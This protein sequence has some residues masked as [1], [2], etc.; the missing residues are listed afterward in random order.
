MHPVGWTRDGKSLLVLRTLRDRTGQIAFLSI[1]DGSLRVVKSPAG[2]DQLGDGVS[3][4]P[5]DRFIAYDAPAGP[6][7]FAHDIF[8]L[9]AD[10]SRETVVA[11]SRAEDREPVWSPDGSQI[12]FR[13]N[14]TGSMALWTVH[15]DAGTPKGPPE[16]VRAGVGRLL[17]M[18]KSGA[19]Y[20]V[21]SGP[22]TNIY[23]VEVDANMTVTGAPV[24]ATN[25]SSMGPATRDGPAT[26]S[27]WPISRAPPS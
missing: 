8:V 1:A 3:L 22:T 15:I 6:G 20:H 18:T 14:R 9:A 11:R 12:L 2:W 26:V 21:T 13:S 27:L 16:P 23:S 24:L 10:G 25:R 4:S 7:E 17:G 19:L 5:D